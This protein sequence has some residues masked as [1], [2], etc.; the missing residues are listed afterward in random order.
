[1]LSLEKR[2]SFFS[3]RFAKGME[4][5]K[6]RT[7]YYALRGRFLALLSRSAAEKE[8][9]SGFPDLA[10]ISHEYGEK[11]SLNG[12][13][14]VRAMGLKRSRRLRRRLR[15]IHKQTW[16]RWGKV[17]PPLKREASISREGNESLRLL[18]CITKVA[19]A[20]G[21]EPRKV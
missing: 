20:A 3:A 17:A 15:F 13:I 18:L 9:G 7:I 21:E 16:R 5:G 19:S 8:T 4:V 12:R 1:M 2:R 14:S 11:A 10:V 6:G